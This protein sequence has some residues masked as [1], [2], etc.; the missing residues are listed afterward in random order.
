MPFLRALVDHFEGLEAELNA[1]DAATG[2]GDHGTTI[3][4][5]LRAAAA[6]NENPAKAFRVASGG[7]S[8]SLFGVFIGALVTAEAAPDKLNGELKRAADRIS[9]L[10]QAKLGDKTMLDALIPASDA[11][12]G[13]QDAARAAH[14]GY[15]ATAPLEAKRG[16]AHYVEGAGKGHL[17]AGARSVAEILAI[18]AKQEHAR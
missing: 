4:R 13:H 17:D 2:D 15:L 10:G 5:G 14:D 3:L 11:G 1:L 7:A 8:G 18:F 16:R 12:P 6:D 9:L